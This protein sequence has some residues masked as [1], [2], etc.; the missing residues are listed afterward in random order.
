[1]DLGAVERNCA[2]LC[3]E[4]AGGAVLC[5]VVKADAYGHGVAGCAG[6]ALRGGAGWLAVATASEAAE[7]R[8]AEPEAPLLTM[9]ALSPDEL[10]QALEAG[11]DVAV[12]RPGFLAAIA[13]AAAA[14]GLT[15]R[16]H[17]KYDT[18][19]GRL[20]ERDPRA[21]A[22]LLRSAAAE[23]R[24]ELAGL[25]THFA[26][27]DEPGS[28]FFDE[29]SCARFVELVEPAR[30]E[31]PGLLVHA[32]N[33]AATLRDP[34]SHFDMVRCG[35]AV[36]GLDPFQEDPFARELEPAL[37][38]RSYVADV[39]RFERGASAGYGQVW[40]ASASTWVG[41]LPIGYGD[42]V[43]RALTNNAEVL[44]DGRRHP[45]VGT[46]S[47]DN[48][49]IDL[50]PETEIEPG[51]PATLIGAQGSERILCEEVARRLGTIN[52]EVTTQIS[53]R[54]PR[55]HSRLMSPAIADSL[56]RIRRV[57]RVPARRWSNATTS[58]SSAARFATRRSAARWS[59]STWRPPATRARSPRR[60]PR[61]PAATP[62]SS[63]PSSAPGARSPRAGPGT[64][65][66][67]AFAARPSRP[68]CCSATSP[69]TRS[70][71][72]LGAA[73]ASRSIRPRGLAD[74]DRGVLRAT[75]AASFSD[76]PLR[77][78]RAARL[79][80]ELGF[81]VDPGTVELALSSAAL[82]G[83]P[84]G[85]RQLSELRLLIS[86]PDPI[87][88]LEAA[89]RA[90]RHRGPSCPRSRTFAASSR[91]PT[92]T[93]TSTGTRS[94]SCASCSSSRATSSGSR[95]S[96]P[97][98]F[99]RCSTSPSATASP[100]ARPCASERCCTTSAS[101]RHAT[102]SRAYVT[103]IGHDHAGAEI[104]GELRAAAA[105]QPARSTPTCAASPST[106][107]GSASSPTSAR[108]PRRQVHEYLRA[109]EPV[110]ADV[111]LL[112]VADRLSARGEGPIASPEMVQA[113]LDLAREMLASRPR[114]A[115]RRAATIA[116]PRRR[117]RRRAGDR[118]RARSWAGCSTRSRRRSTRARSR[119]RD[120]AI[121]L[122]R[123]LVR[124][125]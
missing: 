23:P 84:A 118:A 102:T 32:A 63:R 113:H 59:T 14:L 90:R 39:K 2:R 18:G 111:T 53:S 28:A 116:D 65:T 44:A 20:G 15:P 122:A 27:A 51:E 47:M 107:C 96:A 26:T 103:F 78:L 121:A 29:P 57:R 10:R 77:I 73:R 34:A 89:R 76:D 91:T 48:L 11:S 71:S 45:I 60:S 58:G 54:V 104:V 68:T 114:P 108:C 50:G 9:G 1:M 61:P 88:G 74:L 42:G 81:A 94:R 3:R 124:T 82:A 66:S 92:T 99:G 69:S 64:S 25:W 62:S 87:G 75:S 17:V 8:A 35:I 30:A 123:G 106:T 7:V 33:S 86:S 70:R 46:V 13:E 24:V 49:T 5:A 6:A 21:V 31:H 119:A 98:I 55:V 38:L 40:R 85:E 56:S 43:R 97:A 72:P 109:T 19:M 100:A 117:A 16:V 83:E 80:A 95:A 37:E 93:S 101:R 12:W 41:V 52:Y 4:L 105:R 125:E 115:P 36:Y 67:P 112:T 110:S 22:E 120:D 79:A